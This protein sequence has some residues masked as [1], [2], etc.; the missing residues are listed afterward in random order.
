MKRLILPDTSTAVAWWAANPNAQVADCFA[1]QLPTGQTLYATSGQW[2]IT[3]TGSMSPTGGTITFKSLQYGVWSRGKITSEAGFKCT[4]NTTTLT[5]LPKAGAM[6]PGS[7]LGLFSAALNHLFDAATVF[8]YTAY[9]PIN[10]YGLVEV[11]ETLF[12]GTITKVPTLGRAQIQ[13]ECADPFYLLNMKVPTRLMQ[14]NCAWSFADDPTGDNGRCF[15]NP[16]NYTV[17]FTASSASTQYALTPTASFTQPAG[18]FTQGVVTCVTGNNAGLSQTV[19]LHASG[20]LTLMV[21]WLMPVASGDTFTAIKG[22]DQT[23]TTCAGMAHTDGTPES[24]NWEIRFSGTP[25]APAPTAS[26]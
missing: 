20:V 13:F 1:I 6:Y 2:D 22:C 8:I 23:P 11:F 16:T 3:V 7:S 12:Q 5:L 26:L 18:Y 14:S 15:L 19:K 24:K 10:Q 25:F 17:G 21:P 9:T 4:S